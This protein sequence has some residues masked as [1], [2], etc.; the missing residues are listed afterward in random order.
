MRCRIAGLIV[1]SSACVGVV[2]QAAYAGEGVIDIAAAVVGDQCLIAAESAAA[3]P[4]SCV[5]QSR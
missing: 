2:G 4:T 3:M 5:R 1:S